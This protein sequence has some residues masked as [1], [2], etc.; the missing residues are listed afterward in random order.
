MTPELWKIFLNSDA[1]N[2]IG[3]LLLVLVI[4]ATFAHMVHTTN[5]AEFRRRREKHILDDLCSK[6]KALPDGTERDKAY[7]EYSAVRTFLRSLSN[8]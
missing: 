2:W 7:A 5:S 4:A 8:D 1:T 3:G 6:Y